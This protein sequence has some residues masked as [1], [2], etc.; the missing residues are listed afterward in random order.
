MTD[1]TVVFPNLGE[2]FVVTGR[3]AEG[4]TCDVFK[5]HHVALDLAVAVKVLKP[6]HAPDPSFAERMR[7]EAQVLPRLKSRHVVQCF[8][9]GVTEDGRPYT[10][11]EFLRGET[12]E[13]LLDRTGPLDELTVI[14]LGIALLDALSAV[15]AHGIVHRDVSLRNLI[16]HHTEHEPPTLKLIDFGF[17]LVLPSA[18]ASAPE[19]A[20]LVERVAVGTPRFTAPEVARGDADIDAR[21]DLYSAG[22]VLYTLL[23]GRDP[24]AELD[25][26]EGVLE[27]HAFYRVPPLALYAPRVSKELDGVVMRLL[28]KGRERRFEPRTARVALLEAGDLARGRAAPER[29]P[30]TTAS[31]PPP[32]RSGQG[33]R[34]ANHDT[35]GPLVPRIHLLDENSCVATWRNVFVHVCRGSLTVATIEKMTIATRQL[36]QTTG[37]PLVLITIPEPCAPTPNDAV[38]PRYAD[39]FRKLVPFTVLNLVVA[40]GGQFR[41]SAVRSVG[42]ALSHRARETFDFVFIRSIEEAAR[43]AAPN[44]VPGLHSGE[45][46]QQALEQIRFRFAPMPQRAAAAL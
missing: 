10:V 30:T 16:V 5:A 11:L 29:S 36:N 33:D 15:H 1:R 45:A 8:D 26:A 31:V 7:I 28:E 41:S 32:L 14:D 18:P 44:V 35:S 24:F 25:T 12:L 9:R 39:F 3:H 37:I 6:E 2:K 13:S 46:L 20:E 19:P 21:A 17:A 34:E 40:E 38:R 27:A 22:C 42:T 4:A 23:A 43:V